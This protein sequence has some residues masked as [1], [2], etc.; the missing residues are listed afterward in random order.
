MCGRFNVIDSPQVRTLMEVLG[1]PFPRS[2]GLRFSADISPASPIS[3]VRETAMGREIT[4]AIWWLMLDPATGKPT[5]Y[6]S[7]NSRA[8]KLHQ[9]RA[10]AYAPYR[11]SR[12][13]IPA[14]AFVEGFGDGKR[15]YRIALQDQ[16]ISFGG[17][18]REVLH[19]E[20]GEVFVGASIIT[21]G[22]HP[23]W[24]EIH[25]DSM[26]LMLPLDQPDVLDA[27]LD[28]RQ[29]DVRPFEPLLTPTIRVAQQVTPIDRPSKWNPTGD[30]LLIPAQ[31]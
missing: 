5:R 3:L 20:T 29:Q 18:Y 1:I 7:F 4:D 11:E 2:S 8:D 15:Y 19:P 10:L 25:P 22:P 30:T 21:L 24:R 23:A 6:T 14:S 16:A 12:C 27:W 17:L 31:G 9:P 13:I 26:P 28:P